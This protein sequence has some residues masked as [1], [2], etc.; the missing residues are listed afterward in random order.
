MCSRAGAAPDRPGTADSARRAKTAAAPRARVRDPT[1]C[2]SPPAPAGRQ[3]SVPCRRSRAW[4]CRARRRCWRAIRAASP[5]TLP[6]GCR[7]S[8]CRTRS[9]AAADSAPRPWCRF[10]GHTRPSRRRPGSTDSDIGRTRPHAEAGRGRAS[11][12]REGSAPVAGAGRFET[13]PR[14]PRRTRPR[15]QHQDQPGEIGMIDVLDRAIGGGVGR[16]I[17]ASPAR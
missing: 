7:R 9:S 2:N 8:R 12:I 16:A 6:R 14:P 3:R 10:R 1:P 4:D 5:A 17:L 13:P 11:S 15:R